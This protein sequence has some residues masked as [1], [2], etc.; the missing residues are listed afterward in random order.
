MLPQTPHRPF[1]AV[2]METQAQT[3]PAHGSCARTTLVRAAACV[4]R[5]ERREFAAALTESRDRD[6][7]SLI[8]AASKQPSGGMPSGG[9]KR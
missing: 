6:D 4:Q 2:S 1:D 7:S 9:K 8:K 3:G 5:A